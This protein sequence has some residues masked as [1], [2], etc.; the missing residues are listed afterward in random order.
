MTTTHNSLSYDVLG[1]ERR[2]KLDDQMPE[3]RRRLKTSSK[4]SKPE[5]L[6]EKEIL[7]EEA[8]TFRQYF[9]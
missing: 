9:K 8:L 5:D 6:A 7:P 2:V 4:Q 1:I 3:M